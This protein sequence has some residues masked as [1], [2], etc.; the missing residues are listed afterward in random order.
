[1]AGL[2]LPLATVHVGMHVRLE[3][4][5]EQAMR[6]AL[7][8]PQRRQ[9]PQ[10]PRAQR[11]PSSRRSRKLALADWRRRGAARDRL[12]AGRR[13]DSEFSRTE[14]ADSARVYTSATMPS[15]PRVGR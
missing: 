10:R 11:G 15:E 7:P 12:P 13:T 9:F 5:L 4:E 8:T 1:M 3:L 2:V 6:T 14:V